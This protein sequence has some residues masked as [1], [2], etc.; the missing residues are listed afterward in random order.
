MR[1]FG[2]NI[3]CYGWL[4]FFLPTKT[5]AQPIC[6]F[7]PLHQKLLKTNPNYA[8]TITSNEQKIRDYIKTHPQNGIFQSKIQTT[9]YTI[10]IVIHVMHTGDRVG[11]IYNPTKTQIL[12]AIDY[13][14]NV[15]NGTYQ[16][17]SGAGNLQI[18]FELAK[19]DPNSNCT[20]GIDRV[21]A[22][23]LPGYLANGINLDNSNGCPE[24]TLKNYSRWNPSNYYNVWIVNKIDGGQGIAGFAYKPED[25]PSLDGIVMLASKIVSGV[26]TLPHEMGHALNLYHTFEG[27]ESNTSC[28]NNDSC[29]LEGDKICD[30]DPVT[31]NK[32][33]GIYNFVCR[34]GINDCT[35]TP[36]T[37]NTE[38]NYM[39]YTNC[40]SLFTNNQKTRMQASMT[41]PSRQSLIR[42]NNPA[43]LPIGD[44]TIINPSA[45]PNTV[46]QGN[47]TTVFF[48]EDN[49]GTLQANPNYVNFHLSTDNILTPGLNGD[50]YLDQYYVNQTLPP[51]SQTILLNKQL[52]IPASVLP[53]TYYLFFAADGTGLINECNEENNFATAII[54]VIA[55]T[56]FP[57]LIIQN[58]QVPF[59]ITPGVT[60]T[61]SC[62]NK[63]E[64]SLNADYSYTAIWLSKDQFFNQTNNGTSPDINLGADILVP[65]LNS[66]VTSAQLAQQITI[67]LGTASGSWYL[68]FGADATDRINE[69]Y[70]E[71]N[72]QFFVPFTISVSGCTSPTNDLC[73]ANI[74]QLQVGTT[75]SFTSGNIACAT[76]SYT[77]SGCPS[78]LIQDV[79]YKFTAISNGIY[80]IRLDPSIGMDGVLEV[81][82]GSC[83]GTV[84][85]CV[86]VG[87]GPGAT[88]TLD[89]NVTNGTVYYIRVYEFNLPGNTTPPTT[90]SFNICVIGGA[91]TAPTNQAANISFSN[92]SS[93]SMTVNWQNGN[94]S[95]R[96]VKMN[97]TN[98]FADPTNGSNPTANSIYGGFGEQV[99]YNGN[100]NSVTINGLN[101]ASNSYCFRVYEA[102]CIETSSLYNSSTSL[103]NPNCYAATQTYSII[104][105]SNPAAGGKTTGAGNYSAGQQTTVQA[106]SNSGYTFVNWTENGNH[107]SNI[108]SYTFNVTSNRN[109]L[110]NFTGCNYTLNTNSVNI[111]SPS[112]SLSF[113]VYTTNDCSWTAS[114]NGCSGMITLTNAT[115][116]GNGLVTFNVSSNASTS[117]RSCT[118]IVGSQT[119]T[120][121]Q[122]GYVAPCASAPNAPNSLSAGIIGSNQT[123][124]SWTGSSVNVT[125]FEV[126][127]SLSTAGP[128]TLIATTGTNFGYT[129]NT[130]V[131][132]TTYYYRVRAC[133]NTNCSSY[134]NVVSQTACSFSSKPTEIIAS[135]TNICL[136]DSVTLTVQGGNLGTGAVWTWRSTQCNSGP[137][138]STGSRTIKVAPNSS[139]NYVVKPE[140]GGCE[141]S[142]SCVGIFITVN[143]VPAASLITTNGST[144]FCSGGS[145]M[146]SG[147]VGGIWSNGATT[148]SITVTTS[149]DYF[150]TNTNSCG[151]ANSNHILVSV[152]EPVYTF[153]GTGYWDDASNWSN[154]LIPPSPLNQCSEIIIDPVT[155]GECVLNVPQMILAGGKLTVKPNKRLRILNDLRIQPAVGSFIDNR[156]GQTY[157]FKQIGSQIWM[158]KNLNYDVTGSWC[159]DNNAG[160]CSFYGRLYDWNTAIAV[161]PPGWHIPSDEEW[162]TLISF[163]GGESVAG[164]A[165]KETGTL[166]WQS[167]NLGATNSSE[168]T[169]LPSGMRNQVATFSSLG[170]NGMMWSSTEKNLSESYGCYL[171]NE[172]TSAYRVSSNK[173]W[174][175]SIRCVKDQ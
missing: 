35:G 36:Y 130:G 80:T 46:Q 150:V 52:T 127:R 76:Q 47:T 91:C 72:N 117:P 8:K 39:A 38:S 75:C 144:D 167:P 131:P 25:G 98:S 140:G 102:N 152:Y 50:I 5:I 110:A 78:G 145:V 153:N 162:E 64:G 54:N 160:N 66:G 165:M 154:N 7:D 126:E 65:A 34:T 82:Q 158:T 81:R 56:P 123:Y 10:P 135:S 107:V 122:N 15:Y 141:I 103:N 28:A 67:P 119:F 139:G 87:G 90:T 134:S 2:S 37:P 1:K 63:N 114:T 159:Y 77:A 33:L 30:T 112:A 74:P 60:T 174:G 93:N 89:I 17:T 49:N 68:M 113:W 163:L 22:S 59:S 146:L 161:A 11:S 21:D 55:A 125:T 133:C 124:L 171:G 172:Y 143:Q 106:T 173:L 24:I 44:L 138:V 95:R 42:N 100:G 86:D 94:G 109:L 61:V 51:Y 170:I 13:L 147:N 169:A 9:L 62:Q 128:F 118:I 155:N 32:F 84:L 151:S 121:N 71:N 18:Q 58:T 79:W 26:S 27:S 6:G 14:N 166:Y 29:N 20:D 53:G 70:N 96:I 157:P 168:F 101:T 4:L 57:D 164:S 45:S 149:G 111:Y 108:P 12:S 69:G 88:E 85:N 43:I 19:R 116:T 83:S 132:G 40:R 41:L 142:L 99:V 148:S 105:T 115:G 136:G 97:K 16:G 120:V 73:S 129:D 48:A 104:T 31:E 137:I 3:L 23:I 156:D 92:I 175:M